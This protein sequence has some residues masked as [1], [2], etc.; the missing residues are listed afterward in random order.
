MFN[1]SALQNFFRKYREPVDGVKE[2]LI[3][4]ILFKIGLDLDGKMWQVSEYFTSLFIIS[5]KP[6]QDLYGVFFQSSAS[7]FLAAFWSASHHLY[8]DLQRTMWG[9]QSTWRNYSV[10]SLLREN[11]V[12]LKR[13]WEEGE[14][15]KHWDRISN[16]AARLSMSHC[17]LWEVS[18][19]FNSELNS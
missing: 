4:K 2:T 14:R 16:E 17:V 7:F 3:M 12:C 6:E 11:L 1:S 18:I 9:K 13:G 15:W 10:I 5:L 19:F 8:E